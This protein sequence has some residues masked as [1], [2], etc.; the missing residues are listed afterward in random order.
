MTTLETQS[1][2]LGATLVEGAVLE[3]DRVPRPRGELDHGRRIDLPLRNAERLAEP[4]AAACEH[5]DAA[6]RPGEIGEAV[7]DLDAGAHL[8]VVAEIR[9]QSDVAVPGAQPA[10]LAFGT[11]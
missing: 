11:L 6:A 2:V 1:P 5:G 9:G 3:Q 10:V 7:A 4:V 8:S